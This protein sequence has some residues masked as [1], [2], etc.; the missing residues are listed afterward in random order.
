MMKIIPGFFLAITILFSA[1]N[2]PEKPEVAEIENDPLLLQKCN[3]DLTDIIVHDIFAP[4]VASRIYAYAS[5][6]Y[7]EA[8]RYSNID[9]VPLPSL[10]NQLKGFSKMPEPEPGVYYNFDA[11]AIKAFFSVTNQLTFSKDSIAQLREKYLAPYRA[12][13]KAEVLERSLA[14]GDSIAANILKR[15][16]VDH[17]KQTRSMPRYS[18]F[19]KPGLWQQ[20]PPDYADATE[21][22][23]QQV[24]PILMDSA[25]QFKPAPPTTYSTDPKSKFYKE[26]MEVYNKVNTLTPHED[27]IARFWDDNSFVVEHSGHMMF[28]TKKTT[29]G[30]HWIGIV[31]TLCANRNLSKTKSSQAIALAA[32]TMYDAF[33]SCWDEKYR[34]QYIRPVTAIQ[35]M[36]DEGWNPLLQTPAFPE[37][38]S[39][40]SVISSSVARTMTHFFGGPIPYID[41]SEYEYLHLVRSFPSIEKAAEEACISRLYGG[42]HFRPSIE[43]GAMQGKKVGDLFIEKIKLN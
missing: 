42:I 43:N 41:S 5:L 37:Y 13:V 21:P 39:G 32:V 34:S 1:C 28:A 35:D 17:Y 30:G 25:S 40:H 7:F 23:W 20:T 16:E 10:V 33:I 9:S 27:S 15:N 31:S 22:H 6:A 24:M 2:E 12:G 18:V 14:F 36:V 29:P 19:K 38:T 4:P 11:A 3:Y 26:M 8:I